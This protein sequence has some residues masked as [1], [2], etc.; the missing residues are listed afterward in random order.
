MVYLIVTIIVIIYK[1]T[2]MSQKA[3][4][5]SEKAMMDSESN[6]CIVEVFKTDPMTGN[7]SDHITKLDLTRL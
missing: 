6:Y 2:I 1:Y 7:L 3:M 5:D 4:M